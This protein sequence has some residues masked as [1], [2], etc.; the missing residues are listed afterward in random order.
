MLFRTKRE[1]SV[2]IPVNQCVRAC[3]GFQL[4]S[5]SRDRCVYVG[6]WNESGIKKVDQNAEQTKAMFK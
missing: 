2:S 4:R 6:S 3:S 1:Q 5:V